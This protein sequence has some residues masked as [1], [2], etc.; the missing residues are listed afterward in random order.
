VSRTG[1]ASTARAT[2]ITVGIADYA[3]GRHGAT[4]VTMGLGSCVAIALHSR[5]AR[6]GALAHVLLPNVLL[7]TSQN[8]PG[9]FASTALPVMLRRMR[10]LG[11]GADIQA[12]LVGGSSMF[13]GLLP[14]GAVSLG[15]RNVAAARAACAQHQVEVT[16]ED[17]G[18]SHGRSVFLDAGNGALLVRSMHAGDVQ[19]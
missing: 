17:V 3:V 11:A 1:L 12:R 13:S 15:S 16:G 9:K 5:D 7:S 8:A 2:T 4:L 19:L 6:V 10:E 14:A 18:G